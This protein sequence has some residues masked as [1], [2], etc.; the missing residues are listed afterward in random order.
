MSLAI[1]FA[2]AVSSLGPVPVATP[3]PTDQA[4]VVEGVR[5]PRRRASDFLDKVIPP[6]MDARLGRFEDPLCPGA[7]GLPPNLRDEVLARIRTV[8]TATS[9]AVSGGTCTP[10]L[11]LIVVSDKNEMI[12]G[13]RRKRQAYL[14][15]LGPDRLGRMLKSKTPVVSWQVTDVIGADGLPLRTD[16]DG[17]P[18]LFT[19]VPPSRLTDTTRTRLLA[20]VVIVETRAL[21]RVSTRQIADYALVRTLSPIQRRDAQPPVSS[22]LSLFNPGVKPED[23]PQSVTWWDVALLRALASTRSDLVAS[24]QRRELR[25]MIV[26]EMA[27][28]PIDRR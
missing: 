10:N 22:V 12:E 18:R 16:G 27:K 15:G 24:L 23:A 9:I 17:F 6:A 5:D 4:I 20:G 13:M 19:T 25:D 11:L 21:E 2:A 8:A 3:A 28:V 14:Y 7:I 1:A 26:K